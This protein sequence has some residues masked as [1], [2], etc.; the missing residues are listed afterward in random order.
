MKALSLKFYFSKFGCV[1][2]CKPVGVSEDTIGR[3]GE[4]DI[5]KKH[6]SF[7]K[8]GTSFTVTAELALVVVVGDDSFP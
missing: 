3:V 6:C 5:Y 8:V 4:S 7:C 2:L 1:I